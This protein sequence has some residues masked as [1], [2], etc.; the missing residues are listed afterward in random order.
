MSFV[1]LHNHTMYSLLDG[2]V[3]VRDLVERA[4]ALNMPAV[5]LTDHGNLFGTIPF[6]KAMMKAG[7][8]PIIGFEAYVAPQSRKIKEAGPKGEVNA[9][10]LILLARNLEGYRN[11]MKLSSI[12][13]KE[14]FY[15]K[16]RIDREVLTQHADGLVCLSACIKGEVPW[17]IIQENM[18][19]ARE[20]ALFYREL[21][22]D[23]YYLEVQDHGIPEERIAL[24]GL[25]ELS[26]ELSIPLVATNDS[27]Y[28]LREHAKAQDILICIQTGKDYDDPRRLKFSTDEIYFKSAEEMADTFPSIPRP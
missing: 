6:Y 5:A 19:G 18:E 16:P 24:K 12:G 13:Y 1:H 26:R 21:F 11:L 8:K 27:H 9:H 28:L 10:H 20:D 3:R 22:G 15:Y 2:A 14:G 7:I 17:K 23:N 4:K 25:V